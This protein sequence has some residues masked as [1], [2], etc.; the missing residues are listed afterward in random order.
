MLK[1]AFIISGFAISFIMIVLGLGL[2]FVFEENKFGFPKE[3][4]GIILIG[5]GSFRGYRAYLAWKNY[6]KHNE[7]NN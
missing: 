5:W 7:H 4:M 1:D 2:I 3:V 6:K